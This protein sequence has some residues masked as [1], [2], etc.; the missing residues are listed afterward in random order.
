MK[1]EVFVGIVIIIFVQLVFSGNFFDENASFNGT[2]N[3]TFYNSS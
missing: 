3:W 1:K 2:Y